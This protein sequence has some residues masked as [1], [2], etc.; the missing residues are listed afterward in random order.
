L[1]LIVTFVV[2]TCGLN[3]VGAENNFGNSGKWNK[4]Y[5]EELCDLW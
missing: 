4:L 1:L 3:A 2:K 5:S